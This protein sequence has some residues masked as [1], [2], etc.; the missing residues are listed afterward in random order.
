M[1][2]PL[3]IVITGLPCTGKSTL[4]RLLSHNLSIP[5]ISK[6]GIKEV[7]FDTL[8]YADR[9]WSRRLGLS[10][11]ALLYHFVELEVAAGCSL[12]VESN[13]DAPTA[14]RI[15]EAL[16]AKYPFRVVQVLCRTEPQVLFERFKSRAQSTERHPG[17]VEMQNLDE[18]RA[19]LAG[20]QCEAIPLDGKLI[21]LDTTDFG[22]VDY[23]G[24]VEEIRSMAVETA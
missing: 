3:L 4:G 14:A 11:Y 16:R 8:G 6:D 19:A 17:H 20:V 24:V 23:A 18:F 1:P 12:I 22:L 2:Q 15:F 21:T 9:D 10:S 13:F 7:L 5:Y